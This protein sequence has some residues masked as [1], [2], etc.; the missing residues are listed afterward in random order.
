MA[1][2]NTT[3]DLGAL[4]TIEACNKPVEIEIKHPV[5]LVGTG[6]FFSIIGKDGD[7]YRSRVRA[8]ADENL[9][10]QAAGKSGSA[11]ASIDKLESKNIDA[12]VA[13]TSGWRTGDDPAVTIKG[14]R[15][16]FSAANARKIYTEILPIREQVGEAINDYANFMPA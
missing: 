8:M 11:D 10:R 12:L 15:L 9:R 2:S 14:E 6:V 4:D 13:A 1:K 5:T 7:A 16:E 3:F